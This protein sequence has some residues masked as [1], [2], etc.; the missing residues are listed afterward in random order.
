MVYATKTGGDGQID[1]VGVKRHVNPCVSFNV[2]SLRKGRL[3]SALHQK[4]RDKVGFKI[5]KK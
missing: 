2:V 3:S 1:C 5:L 4:S